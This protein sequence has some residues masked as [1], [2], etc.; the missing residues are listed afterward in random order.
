MRDVWNRDPTIKPHAGSRQSLLPKTHLK[1]VWY[2]PNSFCFSTAIWWKR[3]VVAMKTNNAE[4][5]SPRTFEDLWLAY[6]I[7]FW[8]HQIWLTK[9][10]CCKSHMVPALAN[11][12]VECVVN[13]VISWRQMSS[14]HWKVD[15]PNSCV[16]SS[17]LSFDNNDFLP[18]I[19]FWGVPSLSMN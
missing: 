16:I 2:S 5:L 1:Q 6:L 10:F 7:F 15:K 12:N 3:R 13:I 11:Q 8:Q 18:H 14:I 4:T 17:G 9:G 19:K